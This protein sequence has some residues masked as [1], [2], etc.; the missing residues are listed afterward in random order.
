LKINIEIGLFEWTKFYEYLAQWMTVEELIAF[1]YHINPH[2]ESLHS[3]H[4]L[5]MDETIDDWYTRSH[6]ITSK[7]LE[8]SQGIS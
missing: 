1:K 6:R 8:N 7:I 3:K 2:Y 4:A 5:R